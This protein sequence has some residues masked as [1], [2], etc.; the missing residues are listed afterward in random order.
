[1]KKTT[2]G[3]LA[4]GG[5]AVLLLGG[6]GSLAYWTAGSTVN[7]G[8]VNSGHLKLTDTT[9]GG[10][11]AAVWVID[12][13]E[14][15]PGIT[16]DPATMKLVPGDVI[17]KTCTYSI[18]AVGEHLRANASVTGGSATGAL[19]PFLTVAGTFTD[20]GTPLTS[21]TEANNNDALTAKITVTFNGASDNTSF[22]LNAVLSD[23]AVTLTQVHN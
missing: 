9:T 12:G 1:M 14:D 6:A 20:G 2:K 13:A 15:R 7:G 19:A 18:D 8:S 23:L 3:A 22:D 16:F 21:I 4:A 10:C 17:T 11:S 5:A